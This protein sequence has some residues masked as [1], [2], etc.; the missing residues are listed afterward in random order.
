MINSILILSV[1]YRILA[2]FLF[3]R[4]LFILQHICYYFNRRTL[5]GWTPHVVYYLTSTIHLSFLQPIKH[6]YS[7]LSFDY[8]TYSAKN[9][10]KCCVFVIHRRKGKWNALIFILLLFCLSHQKN[11]QDTTR[12]L[13]IIVLHFVKSFVWYR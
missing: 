8:N 11:I 12:W 10:G 2:Y 3:F 4:E 6:D 9:T 13:F 7:R 1:L 5:Y